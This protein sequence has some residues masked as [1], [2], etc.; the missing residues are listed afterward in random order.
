MGKRVRLGGT[1]ISWGCPKQNADAPEPYHPL[2][3]GQVG[4][5]TGLL[6]GEGCR[7]TNGPESGPGH[8]EG[9]SVK[10][11]Q[12]GGCSSHLLTPPPDSSVRCRMS[13]GATCRSLQRNVSG[14]SQA[15]GGAREGEGLTPRQ[16]M[17]FHGR[18]TKGGVFK[19]RRWAAK[20]LKGQQ[21]FKPT[22]QTLGN[23]EPPTPKTVY[24]I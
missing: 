4:L 9:L 5:L 10:R 12:L 21:P 3:G 1:Q 22:D 13:Q 11:P 24:G 17:G 14:T 23:V 19:L 15:S 20:G 2:A 18:P 16:M 7:D 6:G 8:G